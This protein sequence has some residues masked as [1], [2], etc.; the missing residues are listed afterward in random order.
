MLLIWYSD[1]Y[2]SNGYGANAPKN[3]IALR[4]FVKKNRTNRRGII[5][6]KCHN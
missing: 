5:D 6:K 3:G 2:I 4:P 1:V